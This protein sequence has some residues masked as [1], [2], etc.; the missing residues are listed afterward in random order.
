MHT[1]PT[2]RAR[3]ALRLAGGALL[4]IA[5]AALFGA[6]AEDVV[7]GDR[8]TVVDVD[9]ARWLRR[10]ATPELTA[11]MLIVTHLHSTAAVCLYGAVAA[12]CFA[13]YRQWRRLVTVVVCVAG[14]LGM[15]VLMKLAFRRE[16]PVLEDPL[17]TLSTFSFPSGHVV[18]STL[19]YGLMVVWVFGRTRH[20]AW[21]LLALL[22]G[23]AAVAT[24]AFTRMYLGVHYLSDVVAGF[25]E[26]VAWLVLCLGA[27][28]AF[29]R[30]RAVRGDG[31]GAAPMP[32]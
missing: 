8:I 13:A 9:I 30:R 15:N 11:W 29:W 16:R 2:E 18:G 26:G 21:R 22:G 24:V 20:W 27:L 12:F 1:P 19:V 10:N 3:L 7:T 23:L 14:G 28:S 6:I 31:P 4:L 32:P 5:A 25:A 17:L